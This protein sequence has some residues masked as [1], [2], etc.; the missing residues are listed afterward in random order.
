MPCRHGS[1]RQGRGGFAQLDVARA[2]AKALL[3]FDREPVLVARDDDAVHPVA[4]AR[5]EFDAKQANAR[6]VLQGLFQR[7]ARQ[8][9]G[10]DAQVRGIGAASKPGRAGKHRCPRQAAGVDRTDQQEWQPGK[11]VAMLFGHFAADHA[12]PGRC[13]ALALAG[14]LLR[15]Q[16]PG[17][18]RQAGMR[19][20]G[21]FHD[22]LLG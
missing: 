5:G 10:V 2:V 22:G 18:K 11:E 12:R 20:D 14:A 4:P 1:P 6:T 21:Q 15:G 7:I 9:Q 8:R 19:P 13:H 16:F 3:D 17:V